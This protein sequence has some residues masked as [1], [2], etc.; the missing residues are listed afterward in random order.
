ME[1]TSPQSQSEHLEVPEIN[2]VP[3]F[4]ELVADSALVDALKAAGITT[5]TAV[6][7]QT[8]PPAAAGHDLIVQ[9]QTGSGKTLAFLLPLIL[10]LRAAPAQVGTF[11]LIVTPT[12]EL[13]IQ[14]RDVMRTLT[15]DIKPALIIGGASQKGQL[16]E[17]GDDR[18]VIV[19]T[20]GRILDLI[21]Q[22][23][24]FLRKCRYF[25]LDEA[26]EMLSMGFLEDVRSILSRLPDKRQGLFISATI[27]PRVQMLASSFLS[28]P[29]TI[30]VHGDLQSAAEIEH[31][32]C[33]VDGELTAKAIALCDIIETQRPRTAIIFC[34]TK[35]DTE[36]VEVFLRRRG[37]DARRINSDLS[38]KQR[39][40][41][42][43]RIREGSL[44]IL[45]ATDVAARGIDIAQ[46]DLVINY[47]IHEQPETYVHRTG[48]TGRAGRK[49]KAI[50]IVGP[51][52]FGSFYGLRKRLSIDLHKMAL[53][54]A[55]EVAEARLAHFYEL[56]RESGIEANDK[57]RALATKLLGDLGDVQL[58]ADELVEMIA[59]LYRLALGTVVKQEA[60]KSLDEEVGGN[61]AGPRASSDDEAHEPRRRPRSGG[62]RDG[63][64][65]RSR[66]GPRDRRR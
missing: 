34:N 20:P 57:E 46:L 61:E 50:S 65:R 60:A 11:G 28:Q 5:P 59:K 3:S 36:L 17:L 30:A 2:T 29:Q 15:P 38:Q 4:A 58:P 26:D 39:E 55:E 43:A 12:R 10:K 56:V 45:V 23:E 54:T 6:Q 49:G 44:P 37:F 31:L 48:R 53:P 19:G 35:S 41:I 8:I 22:R 52:D 33:E 18:R 7:A 1:A 9:A 27:T 24:I 63:G 14:V 42:M 62:G 13:A 16:D 51:H 66:G 21:R 40:R 25:V 64:R 47:A 32:Y